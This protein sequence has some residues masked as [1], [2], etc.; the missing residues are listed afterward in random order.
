MPNYT[1][2]IIH[3]ETVWFNE[4]G[5]HVAHYPDMLLH[6]VLQRTLEQA[7]RTQRITEEAATILEARLLEAWPMQADDS[8][9]QFNARVAAIDAFRQAG[10]IA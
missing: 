4:R 1:A 2:Q 3:G 9:P 10:L 5:E 8:A 6:D 7:E